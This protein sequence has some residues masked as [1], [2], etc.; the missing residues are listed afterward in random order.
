MKSLFYKTAVFFCGA[1]IP[2][3]LVAAIYVY[4]G[5][6]CDPKFGCAGTLNLILKISILPVA[7]LSSA[8][9]L[10]CLALFSKMHKWTSIPNIWL[11]LLGIAISGF[12]VVSIRLAQ[13]VGLVATVFLIFLATACALFILSQINITRR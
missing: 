5:D 3:M 10:V 11:G 6:N 13:D 9:A 1:L 12:N 7:F 2:A 4:V 8:C